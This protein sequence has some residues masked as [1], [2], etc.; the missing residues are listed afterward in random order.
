MKRSAIKPLKHISLGDIMGHG[1]MVFYSLMCLLPFLLLITSSL[2]KETDIVIYGYSF[3]PKEWSA[4]AYSYLWESRLSIGRSYLMTVLVTVVGTTLSLLI[5][6]L[7]AYP[8][9]RP[10]FPFRRVF[11]FFIFFTLLFNGGLVPT[12]LVY[13]NWLGIKNTFFGLILPNLLLSGFHV[14]IM[15]TY[16]ATSIPFS[17]I[18]AATIDGAGEIRVFTSIVA[19]LSLPILATI[20]MLVGINYWN[21]WFNGMVYITD[22]KLYPIQNLL[23]RIISDIQFMTT[24]GSD[25][26]SSASLAAI[27]TASVRMALAVIGVLPILLA[28]PFFQK[29]F[30]KGVA[31][32]AVKG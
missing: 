8:I 10:D 32:G 27:P 15:R 6:M 1:I 18:E 22:S 2:T 9:S 16:F 20:G 14:L 3:F 5:C 23:N 24:M 19:P 12:Y 13:T 17:I 29:Y 25:S 11:N 21:D 7:L 31:V 26:G 4:E 28:Y 30:I